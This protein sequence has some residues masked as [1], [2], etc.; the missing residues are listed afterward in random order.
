MDLFE[1][2]SSFIP[3]EQKA[4]IKAKI[5]GELGNLTKSKETE[6][7]KKHYLKKFGVNLFEEDLLKKRLVKV[8]L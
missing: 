3:D 6:V 4:D 1:I 7:K 5:D 2:V 8:Y